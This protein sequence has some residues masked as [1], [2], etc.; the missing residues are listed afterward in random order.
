MV[1]AAAGFVIAFVGLMISGVERKLRQMGQR[2]A[3]L[4][5]KLDLVL[6]ELGIVRNDPA[7]DRVTAQIRE[8]RAIKAIKTYREIT[9]ADLLEA[10]EA[11]DRLRAEQEAER[12]GAPDRQ[13]R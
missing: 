4:E 7:M 9:G 13:G 2:Q 11:V 12:A 3:R 5:R 6:D 8:G 10:K 1:F